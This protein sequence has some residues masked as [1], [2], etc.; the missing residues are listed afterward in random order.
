MLRLL[1]NV[2]LPIFGTMFAAGATIGESSGGGDGG[3]GSTAGQGDSSDSGGGA[4]QSGLGDQTDDGTGDTPA[5]GREDDAA[6]AEANA[7]DP[8]ALVDSGDGR[9]IPQKYQEL[10]KDDKALRDMYFSQAALKRVF[11]GGVK[12]AVALAK[13]VEEIGG[14]DTVE[15]LQSD[16]GIYHADAEKFNNGDPKWVAES[17]KENEEATLKHFTNAF[18]YI[19][20]NPELNSFH[21]HFVA[22]I[23]KADIDG[24]SPLGAIQDYL[25]AKKDDP[26]AKE[27]AAKLYAYYK[28]RSE[29]A[30][31]VPTKQID[32]QQKKLDAKAA[33]LTQKEQ[34]VRNK[35]INAEAAPYMQRSIEGS[36]TKA[37]KDAGLDLA[38]LQTSPRWQR[39]LKDA[40]SAIHANVLAD[41]KWLDRYSAALAS[42][43]TAKCVRMLNARHDQAINGSGNTP[44]VV[45]PVFHEWFGPPKAGARGTGTR[46]NQGGGAR[47]VNTGGGG[48]ETPMLVNAL[49]PAKDINYNDPATDKWEGIYR[50]KTGKLIQVKRP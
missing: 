24:A 34:Q 4:D 26:A 41:T 20:D 33:E 50:L 3:G 21:D 7:D 13:Q 43:D 45:A 25:L 2:W 47:T 46:Q 29:L 28:H 49:P 17:F 30:Q 23:I 6:S 16:L 14:L 39:F 42:G 8:N 12:D 40:R 35:T 19:V 1:L 18:N 27:L 22:K 10:F 11:P 15:Q 44:G 48:R 38:K 36:L 5:Q 37:A 32:P 9:K 31:K